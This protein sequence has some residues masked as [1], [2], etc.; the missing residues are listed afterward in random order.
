MTEFLIAALF[1]VWMSACAL[2]FALTL[3]LAFDG[4]WLAIPTGIA[5]V[6]LMA[7]FMAW[8]VHS[9]QNAE[10]DCLRSGRAWA[11]VGG[12]PRVTLYG[13]VERR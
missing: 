10:A 3:F 6:A 13:C 7:G 1:I 8:A 12:T 5:A 9:S 4:E 2:A 11:I